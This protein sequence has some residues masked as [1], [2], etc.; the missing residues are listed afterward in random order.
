[1]SDPSTVL[2]LHPSRIALKLMGVIALLCAIHVL[3]MW[4]YYGGLFDFK[5][6][7]GLKYWQITIFD[8][9][10]E[11]SFGTWFNSIILLFAAVLLLA[12]AAR[13][14]LNRDLWFPWWMILGI[15]FLVLSIDEIVGMHEYLNSALKETSWTAVAAVGVGAVGLLFVPFFLHLP[16]RSKLLFL[17]AA[18]L[19]LGGALGVERWSDQFADQDLLDTLEYNLWTA[20]EEVMEMAG[21]V[22]FIFALLAH[23]TGSPK[24]SLLFLVQV[25][26]ESVGDESSAPV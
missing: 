18:I 17:A 25:S 10:E 14:K 4:L 11:E 20:V 13:Q 2:S 8:L 21:V 1:M 5:A 22:L 23:M 6:E 26:P 19:Y 7:Y 24:R 15:G 12:H 9:D 16:M 3:A